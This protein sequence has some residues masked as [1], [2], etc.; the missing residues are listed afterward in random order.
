MDDDANERSEHDDDSIMMVMRVS[1]MLTLS[2]KYILF[3]SVL[4]YSFL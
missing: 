3:Y 2:N 1:M 4:F